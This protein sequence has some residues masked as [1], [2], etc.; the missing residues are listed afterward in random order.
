MPASYE[1]DG[2]R[3]YLRLTFTGTLTADEVMAVSLELEA[4]RDVHPMAFCLV[5]LTGVAHLLLTRGD[6]E[7]VA[8][9]SRRLGLLSP[10][11][12]VAVGAATDLAF[13]MSRMWEALSQGSGWTVRVFRGR[14]E[15]EG[16][17]AEQAGRRPES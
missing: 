15:A 12:T 7:H 10:A 17:L 3:R 6:I 1:V 5:D 9:V 14:E 2:E 16:W 13:G 11:S 8:E 4:N